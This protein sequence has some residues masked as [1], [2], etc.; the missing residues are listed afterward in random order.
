MQVKSKTL[1]CSETLVTLSGSG[2]NGTNLSFEWVDENNISISITNTVDVS[3]DGAYTLFVTND[4]NGCSASSDVAV[5]SDTTA[6]LAEAGTAETLTCVV[7]DV[8]LD[9]SASSVG[10]DISYEWQDENTAIVGTDIQISVASPG[11]YTLIVTD[12]I[13]GCSFED[14]VIVLE[15]VTPP[16]A[17]INTGSSTDLDCNNSSTVLDGTGSSPANQLTFEWTTID[18]NIL[19]GNETPNPEVNAQGTYIL[20]ITNLINGCTDSEPIFINQDITPPVAFINTPQVLTCDLTEMELDATGSSSNGNFN[21]SWTSNPVEG[22][23]SGE[24]TLQPT[25]DQPGTF[26]ITVFDEDNGCESNAEIIVSQ[27]I[28]PPTAAAN[29]DDQ[30]DCVT[31]SLNLD[32]TGSSTGPTFTYSWT[33]NGAIDNASSLAP[34]VYEPG[35]YTILVTDVENGMYSSRGCFG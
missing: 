1:T 24:T 6:P 5:L 9:G 20:I 30:F 10:Q 7:L 18:G 22:I 21:Y 8:I 31:E 23:I 26:I 13:N 32:G 29:V 12:E 25:I 16:V 19:S 3:F 34:T 17:S 33:G 15:D 35:V 14:E 27:N 28:T 11:T 2:S 4:D